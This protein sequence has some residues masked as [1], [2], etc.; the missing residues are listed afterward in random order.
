MLTNAL[1]TQCVV[2]VLLIAIPLSG[3]KSIDA[4]FR[5]ITDLSSLSLVVPYIILAAAYFTF[6]IKGMEA[7]FTM[8]KQNTLACSAIVVL[9]ISIAG[10]IGAGMDY[11]ADAETTGAA[12]KAILMTYGGPVILICAGY[13]LRMVMRARLTSKQQQRPVLAD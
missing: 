6:R 12:M 9:G 7:P 13:G 8:F 4:F 11:L 1:W 2:V 5:L 3:L 10:F